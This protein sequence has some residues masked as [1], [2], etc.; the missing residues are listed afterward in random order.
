MNGLAPTRSV[1]A[2]FPDSGVRVV[3]C[4]AVDLIVHVFASICG[5]SDAAPGEKRVASQCLPD[6]ECGKAGA[7]PDK[8]RDSRPL[9]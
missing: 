9:L 8:K 2:G 1:G 6:L 3:L 4:T 5:L 7:A